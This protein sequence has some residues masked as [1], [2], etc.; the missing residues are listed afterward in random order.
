MAGDSVALTPPPSA[1]PNSPSALPDR[2]AGQPAVSVRDAWFGYR[3][4][5]P[6][7]RSV[8]FDLEPGQLMMVLGASGSGKS[9]LL[10]LVKG[11]IAP[12]RGEVRVFGTP[13]RPAGMRGRL[14]AS[15]AYIP[16]QLGLVRTSTVLENALG[17][18]LGQVP[19]WRGLTGFFPRATVALALETLETLG[20]GHKAH[21]KVRSL[22]GG[23]RQRVAIA[24]A[25]VQRPRVLVADEFV[26]QLD[27]V[28]TG[29]IMELVE[30]IAATGVAVLMTTHELDIVSGFAEQVMLLR[31]GEKVLQC[32]PREIEANELA[33]LM[34][35]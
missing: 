5:T 29:E 14:D 4:A 22:S 9:T 18:A 3:K 23:E 19:T 27:P 12:H 11:L 35:P 34:K 7:L 10:K 16:Q 24:R 6:V 2:P 20:V 30:G 26:S 31:D 13:I 21:Q 33:N 17:G 25:L 8:S 28:T 1:L 15:V 32:G